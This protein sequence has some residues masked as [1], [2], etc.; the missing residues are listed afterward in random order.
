MLTVVARYRVKPGKADDVAAVL[1]K[2]S[3]ATRAEPG[4]L[5]FI[6][7]RSED[8]SDEFL[9]YEQYVDESAFQAH[10]QT[11]HFR[12]YI[13]RLV[14]PLLAERTWH[15]YRTIEATPPRDEHPR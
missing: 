3:L 4:C 11:G 7:Y 5:T 14:V 2:H 1:A 15:R 10:R 12:E 13:E 8:E 9:L 6:A